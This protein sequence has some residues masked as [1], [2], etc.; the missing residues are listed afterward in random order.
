LHII[1]RIADYH[2]LQLC[3]YSRE[4]LK[5]RVALHLGSNTNKLKLANEIL[6]HV[7]ENDATDD[8]IGSMIYYPATSSIEDHKDA[9]RAVF[10]AMGQGAHYAKMSGEG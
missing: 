2:F 1:N 8:S 10:D 6:L 9:F 4:D 7:Y 3:N 5:N